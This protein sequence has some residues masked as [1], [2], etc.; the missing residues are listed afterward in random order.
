MLM[1][2]MPKLLLLWNVRIIES[3]HL[4]INVSILG[5]TK[6]KVIRGRV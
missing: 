5:F 4:L 6:L 3:S 1:D 2:Y